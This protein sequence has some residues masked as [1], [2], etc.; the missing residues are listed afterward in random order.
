MK[1]IIVEN[2]EEASVEAAKV[3]LEVVKNNPTANLG[4]ATGST[5]IRLYELMIE[6]HKK[7][8]TSYKDIKTFNLDEYFGL[9]PTHP[10]SYH[11]FME[12]HLFKDIDINPENVHVPNGAGEIQKSC[13]DYNELLANNQLDI[14][15]L[16]IGS[17]GHI[18]FNEPGTA[19]DSVT[20]MI[21]LKE[22]TRQD[23]ARLFFN[24][25]IDEVP[26][27]AITMGIS[28]ILAAKKLLLVACGENK[29]VPI[30][31]LVEGEKTVDVPASALQDHDDVT[32]IIDKAAA[33]LL[34]K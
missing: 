10:Q 25:N 33:S 20:H 19:F 4:L 12:Q 22:S 5:P 16:G 3:M 14:Q 31:V 15:L 29:A 2:Y 7:N 28:N 18:G 27:H 23:N 30:K 1:V 26:T 9:E 32:V 13:D 6:D 8:G 24:G 21:E 17:N 11:Y 34:T